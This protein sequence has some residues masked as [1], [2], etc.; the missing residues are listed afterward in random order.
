MVVDEEDEEPAEDTAGQKRKVCTKLARVS[1]QSL[2][3]ISARPLP[4]PQNPLRGPRGVS[5]HHLRSR[6]LSPSKKMMKSKHMD[7]MPWILT[8]SVLVSCSS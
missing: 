5:P 4:N 1:N 2:I 3:V 8:V 7:P 6:L